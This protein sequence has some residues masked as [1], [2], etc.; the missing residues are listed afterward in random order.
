MLEFES[1]YRLY[2]SISPFR[3]YELLGFYLYIGI[4]LS[5][6]IVP[7][8]LHFATR[9]VRQISHCEVG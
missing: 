4:T 8:S 5:V 7:Y 9:D 2:S 1:F 3:S 6:Y